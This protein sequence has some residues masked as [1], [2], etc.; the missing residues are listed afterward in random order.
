VAA[1]S[2]DGFVVV[3]GNDDD[4]G[5]SEPDYGRIWVQRYDDA[6]APIGSKIQVNTSEASTNTY[7][8][9]GVAAA[10]DGGFLVVWDRFGINARRFDA[11]GAPLTPE[12]SVNTDPTHSYEFPAVDSNANGDFVVVWRDYSGIYPAED[13]IFGQRLDTDANFVGSEFR[14]SDYGD[15][16]RNRTAIAPDGTVMV[17]GWPYG[18]IAT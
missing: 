10:P 4:D 13:G 3:W 6:N 8:R 1:T 16:F 9:T 15:V 12:F 17:L 7:N 11:T 2:D 5:P 18:P 14:V